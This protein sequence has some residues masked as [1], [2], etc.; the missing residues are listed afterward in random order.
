VGNT[1]RVLRHLQNKKEVEAIVLLA[2][3]LQDEGKSYRIITPYDAQRSELERALEDEDLNWHDKCFN[4]D[5]F[6]GH[7]LALTQPGSLITDMKTGNEDHVIIISVVRSKE[8]GFLTSIRRTNVMLT[9]CQHAMYIVSSK[10]FLEGKGANSL[11]G[12]MA[13]ELGNCPGAWL[14]HKDFEEGRFE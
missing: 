11:I 2:R 7:F 9:R 8:L 5:S 10:G 13:A 14:T 3:Y 4:V 6:Q 12:K 1:N